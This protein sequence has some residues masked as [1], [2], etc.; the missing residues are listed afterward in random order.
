M[1]LAS[2]FL[3]QVL[4]LGVIVSLEQSWGMAA[5]PLAEHV[6][7]KLSKRVPVDLALVTGCA[8]QCL[9]LFKLQT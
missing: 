2:R 4:V 5:M 8:V 3:I 1:S 9:K 7:F 6:G